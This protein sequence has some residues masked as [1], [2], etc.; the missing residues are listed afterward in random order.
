MA[1]LRPVCLPDG[2]ERMTA[3][4]RARGYRTVRARES[5]ALHVMMNISTLYAI[6][7]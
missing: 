4:L 7:D 2:L 1:S 5:W 3:L 6:R